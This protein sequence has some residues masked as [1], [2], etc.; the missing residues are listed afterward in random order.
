MNCTKW[1]V[2]CIKSKV[3]NTLYITNWKVHTQEC[4]CSKLRLSVSIRTFKVCLI[5]KSKSLLV[6]IT[7]ISTQK[8]RFAALHYQ[9]VQSNS[10]LHLEFCRYGIINVW[11]DEQ[12]MT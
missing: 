6:F 3:I 11:C 12:S 10:E 9:D 1:I 4:L 5:S 2:G 7:K 8:S